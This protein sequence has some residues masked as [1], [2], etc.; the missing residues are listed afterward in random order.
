MNKIENIV[1]SLK[2]CDI[3]L[4]LESF[5]IEQNDEITNAV[6]AELDKLELAEIEKINKFLTHLLNVCYHY[7][8][9]E[10]ED[11]DVELIDK[12]SLN[13]LFLYKETVIY[14]LGR[15]SIKPDIEIIKKAYYL[16]DNKYIKLNLVFTSLCTYDEEIELDF[17][18][19]CIDNNEYD[20]MLRSW[21]MAYFKLEKNPYDY[22]DTK[23]SDFEEAKLPR[24]KRLAI[25]DESNKKYEKAMS[26]RLMDLLVIFLF[27]RN[28]DKKYLTNEELDIIKNTN[29][30]FSRYSNTKKELMTYLQSKI[31]EK[32]N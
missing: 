12:L 3:K 26:F 23:D 8:L 11:N 32:S 2:E 15:L 14:F 19:L 31:I 16:E 25:N 13:D 20:L 9:Y 27:I 4:S 28:R 22:I 17:V 24:I 29:I 18:R 6:R 21:T 30:E 10:E 1:K 5:V 7:K